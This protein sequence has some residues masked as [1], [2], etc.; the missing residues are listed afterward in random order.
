M[1]QKPLR[2]LISALVAIAL[3]AVLGALLI[4]WDERQN[5]Q[6]TLII[7]DVKQPVFALLY[8]AE[9]QGYF[10]DQNLTVTLHHFPTGKDAL[11]Q[12]V[13][14]K[15][16]LATT[17]ETPFVTRIHEGNDLLAISTLHDSAQNKAIVSKKEKGIASAKDLAGK[18]VGVNLGTSSEFFLY[19]VLTSQ[20]LSLKDIVPVP[21]DS[22]KL[23]AAL[24]SGSVDAIAAP[25]SSVFFSQ[26]NLSLE[27][28]SLFSSDTYVEISLLAGTRQ[29]VQDNERSISKLITALNKA[30]EFVEADRNSAIDIMGKIMPE[31]SKQELESL[32]QNTSLRLRL[33]NALLSSMER[34]SRWIT[35]G[36]QYS[37]PDPDFRNNIYT[38]YLKRVQP[39]EVTLY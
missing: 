28:H 4:R 38:R 20:G 23:A 5:P 21:L 11:S 18:R 16:Q 32:L 39:E 29:F 22:D 17:Y 3:F 10:D 30:K 24:A 25:N 35:S 37:N 13:A 2:R 9:E 14:G 12:V 26:N 27:N 33:D 15:A 34:E 7:A 36:K 1:A 6:D 31:Y 19:L 8:L